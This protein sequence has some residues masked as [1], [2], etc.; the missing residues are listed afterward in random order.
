[1]TTKP[2]VQKIPEGTLHSEED[3]K[4]NHGSTV[5]KSVRGIDK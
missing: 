1:M 4:H 5:K 3:D 2:A